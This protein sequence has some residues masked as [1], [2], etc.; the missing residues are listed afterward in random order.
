VIR[1]GARLNDFLLSVR[2]EPVAVKMAAYITRAGTPFDKS[3]AGLST[4]KPP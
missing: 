1:H 3:K 2:P 4:P